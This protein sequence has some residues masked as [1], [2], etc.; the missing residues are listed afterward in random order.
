M[1]NSST[2][3]ESA[4]A[5]LVSLWQRRRADGQTVTPGEL[6][7]ERPELL[8][9]LEQRILA[10]ERMA[11]L[12]GAIHETVTVAP[13]SGD[14]AVV[15]EAGT[16]DPWPT[17]PT[18]SPGQSTPT[19]EALPDGP[20]V[21]G[22]EVLGILGKGGM[23]VVYKA[24][25]RGLGRIVALKM[26]LHAEHAG[27]QERQRFQ[28]EAEAVARLQHANIV[29]IHEVGEHKGLPFFS[30]EFCPGGSLA[31]K[32]DGTPLPPREAARLVQTL[33]VAMQA[34]HD[35]GILHRD[36]K[37]AN[38]L[39]S[40]DGTPKITDFGLAK[41]LGEQGQTQTGAVVGTPSYMAP[42]QANGSKTIGPAADIYALGAIL[43]ELLTGRPPFK[44]ATALDTILQVINDEPVP[45]RQFQSRVPRDLETICL[46]CLQKQP[47]RR[48]ASAA[49]LA[50]DLRRF[51][52]G[53]PI[54]A[55]PVGR[56][57]RAWRWCRRNPAL[58]GGIAT[59]SLA[60]VAVAVLGVLMAVAERENAL[61]DQQNE[62][63]EQQRL[64]EDTLKDQQNALKEQQRLKEDALKDQQRLREAL[65]EQARAERLLGNRFRALE[66]LQEAAQNG[67]SEELRQEAIQAVTSSGVRL[68]REVED[69]DPNKRPP[70][71]KEPTF[72]RMGIGMVKGADGGAVVEDEGKKLLTLPPRM[73]LPTKYYFSPDKSW[74][75]F[76][77]AIESGLIRLWDCRIHKL[78]GR[79]PECGDLALIGFVCDP[80]SSD[81]VSL[82]STH[83]R[84]KKGVLLINEVHSRRTLWKREGLIA[85]GWSDD[86]KFLLVRS[87]T[88]AMGV[89]PRATRE[90]ILPDFDQSVHEHWAFTQAWEVSCPVPTFQIPEPIERLIFRPDA[91]QI[92]VNGTL[93][94]VQ[95][96]NGR[97]ALQQTALSTPGGVLSF[98]GGEVWGLFSTQGDLARRTRR[99]PSETLHVI[100]KPTESTEYQKRRDAEPNAIS[101]ARFVAAGP[102]L[103][104]L[105]RLGCIFA[106]FR[107]ARWERPRIVGPLP[108]EREVILAPPN[109]PIRDK[110]W[111][112]PGYTSLTIHRAAWS[113]NG[114]KLLALVKA[115]R[116][117]PCFGTVLFGGSSGPDD[118]I[119]EA[120]DVPSGHRYPLKFPKAQWTDIAWHPDGHRFATAGKQLLSCKGVRV[121]DLA[122]SAELVT[123]AQEDADHVVWSDDGKYLLSVL[124]DKKATLYTSEGRETCSL[125]APN[126]DWFAFSL[127]GQLGYVA[128]GGEDGLIHLRDVESGRELARWQAHDAAVTA[129][130][131][132]PDG[133]L[134]ASGAADGSLRVWNIPW[135][136]SELAAI[137]LDW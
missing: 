25:Q 133:T 93:W 115:W 81:G 35:K 2:S 135:I 113:R 14:G 94:D 65:F 23:G 21:P 67:S 36:L 68:V 76:R 78:H 15:H 45:P 11:E 19:L 17:L 132:S 136:R 40:E 74:I 41:K 24:Q 61:K 137:G 126:K 63:K 22:Y 80:F 33:A 9:Q 120:W 66:L 107:P 129:L 95:L 55:R 5:D 38:V 12:A 101:A 96:G 84:N 72:S 58:A 53:E 18:A 123:N 73:G 127:S 91:R 51:R 43:Y 98:R 8:P 110:Y 70:W 7:R 75:A 31:D 105:E 37:P 82:A 90:S 48:Y 13:K 131:F 87:E 16:P 79:L 89:E 117:F 32:L 69:K 57:E 108:M 99:G 86:G 42:E 124:E 64:K 39:L 85:D 118:E 52:A 111:D 29:Q 28:A 122:T 128:N 104:P 103:S 116:C 100:P 60:L 30:L 50:D 77:D 106:D 1:Q 112:E 83:S 54:L 102:S 46:K 92:A 34:A 26:I 134:L 47:S 49:E 125:P 10:L 62:L 20:S 59:T 44:A 88:S 114:E 109:D 71:Y 130:T 97:I 121:W 3:S 4:L 56:W 27:E 6:C 119:V